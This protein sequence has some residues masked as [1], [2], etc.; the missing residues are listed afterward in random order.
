MAKVPNKVLYSLLM[1]I[2]IQWT[3]V[4]FTY[5]FP[6][7]FEAALIQN[8]GISTFQIEFLYSIGSLPNLFSNILA[9]MLINRIGIQLVAVISQAVIILGAGITLFAVRANSYNMLMGG[10]VFVGIGADLGFL[11]QLVT[12]E[13]WFSGKFLT[14]SYGLG[15]SL[16][17]IATACAYYFLP[18][19]FIMYRNLEASVMLSVAYCT[20]TFITTSIYAVIDLK[21]EHY[22][23][24]EQLEE[25][26]DGGEQ[27]AP[28]EAKKDQGVQEPLNGQIKDGEGDSG[29]NEQQDE[30][31]MLEKKFTLKHL[32]YISA[33]S[34][35]YTLQVAMFIQMYFQF[36]NTAT[37]LLVTRYRLSYQKAKNSMAFIPLFSALL[38]PIFSALYVK[39]GQ[40]PLGVFVS[41]VLGVLSY[42]YLSLLP[43]KNPGIF[44]NIGLVMFSFFFSM[45]AACL[46]SCLV[47]SV[48]KQSAGLMIAI[49]ATVQ[50]LFLTVLPLFFSIFYGPR[51]V[52]AYQT[53]LYSM[54]GYCGVCALLAV[55]TLY[56][57]LKG[58]KILT[59]PEN[60]IRVKRLQMK[61]NRDFFYDVLGKKSKGDKTEYA[62]LGGG[63][64][65]GA[66]TTNMWKSVASSHA[67]SRIGLDKDLHD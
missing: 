40:K 47:I 5:D 37:D 24:V 64:R 20:I 41:S 26:N 51:T 35:L 61:M 67:G 43:D 7:M 66:G 12:A 59:M 15:R 28:E 23:Q 30:T 53:F 45:F 32:N 27:E 39:Y 42:F 50:N 21:N 10:R 36:T 8:M 3:A 6:Q 52:R 31:R 11:L 56:L 9:A 29:T 55:A 25:E 62:T 38:I 2:P 58:D 14:F 18:K 22:L 49:A 60:D 33:K 19:F 63:T 13:R 44:L 46:W 54:M 1:V 17:Y 57:D 4:S 34:W 16:G 48:P 65:T